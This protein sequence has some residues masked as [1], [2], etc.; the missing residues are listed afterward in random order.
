VFVGFALDPDIT[1]KMT[2][3]ESAAAVLVDATLVRLVL[4]PATM[5]LLG[6]ANWW[7]PRRRRPTMPVSR[8]SREPALA[9]YQ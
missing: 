8:E 5:A 1:V 7:T 4:V 9:Q 2:G 6:K 3:V